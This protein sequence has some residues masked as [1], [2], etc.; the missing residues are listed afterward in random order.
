MSIGRLKATQAV[1][2]MIVCL[3]AVLGSLLLSGL[4]GAQAATSQANAH[5]ARA[6]A[7]SRASADPKP[8]MGWS[9]WSFLRFGVDTQRIEREAKALVTSGLVNYGYRYVNIDDNW[10]V[11]PSPQGPEVDLYGRWV[12]DGKEF[13]NVGTENGIAAVAAYVHHL[14]L[15]FGVYETAGISKQAV[16][17][18][19][20]VKGTRYT[21]KQIATGHVQANYDCGGMVDLNYRSP[22]AQ[23]YVDS[24]VDELAHWG[25]DYIKLDGIGDSNGPDIRAWSRA[26]EQSGRSIMLDTTEGSFN[27]K[28]A[29]TLDKYSNQWE[30]APDIEINGPDEGLPAAC[31]KAPYTGCKSVFPF[32]SYSHWSDRF[33][34]VARWQ[35][36]GGPGGFNDYDSI[37]VGDGAAKSGMSPAA[38]QS[39]LSL[40]ALGSASLILGVNLT[41]SVTNAFGSSGGLT[42]AGLGMLENRSV[43]EVDQDAI[44]AS[45]IAD[46]ADSQVFAKREP[47]GDAVVG[48]FD[49][50]RAAGARAESLSTTAAALGLPADPAGYLVQDLWTG[51]QQTVAAAGTI[52][53]QVAAEGVA[54]LR[55]TPRASA[56]ST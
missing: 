50:D 10:Y 44:D 33:N 36:Y 28:L 5:G 40:W 52:N 18:N 26:I 3:V 39:Q 6:K 30:F 11:C 12:V 56:A 27:T 29:P 23:A 4:T 19:T 53:A 22:G 42:K 48:L 13:P 37:E 34:D 51:S 24:V 49:T 43:I 38:E 2:A 31:N 21:A 8:V 15:K 54:L 9:S 55:V 45:R 47:S 17:E 14:G 35:P 41:S 16:A 46:T 1:T 20:P 32:T 25:V 7:P